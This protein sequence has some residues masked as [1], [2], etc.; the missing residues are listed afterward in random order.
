MPGKKLNSF[1]TT[2]SYNWN[3]THN[4]GSRYCSLKIEA[5]AVGTTADP[6]GE[7]PGRKSLRKEK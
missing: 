6:T 2:N 1:T 5:L 3:I 4:T 7:V